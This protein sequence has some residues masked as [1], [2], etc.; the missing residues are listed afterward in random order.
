M[1]WVSPLGGGRGAVR[2]LVEIVLR[3]QGRWDGGRAGSTL[4]ASSMSPY[5]TLLASLLAL[6]AG[7][8][9]GKAWERYKLRDGTL[10]RSPARARVARTTCSGSTSWSPTR[11]TWRSRS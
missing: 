7:L 4:A 5:A 10:D 6:L 2:E 3:A 8:I 11:S 9:V 1:H